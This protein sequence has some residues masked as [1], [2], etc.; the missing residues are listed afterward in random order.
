MPVKLDQ[1]DKRLLYLLYSYGK[2]VSRRRLH[3]LA[4]RLQK[5]YGVD[6]GFEFSGQP[7]F[8]KELDEKV[9][10]LAERGLLKV[11]YSVGRSYLNLYKPYYKLTEKGARVIEKTEFSKTDKELIEKM[12]NEI[13][14]SRS[15]E[16][17]ATTGPM[18]QQ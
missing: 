16:R 14:A 10:S 9:Q 2:A 5:D 12:V 4:F 1:A 18:D 13:R 11:V 6:L 15:S 3:E 7:P 8:S 17:L